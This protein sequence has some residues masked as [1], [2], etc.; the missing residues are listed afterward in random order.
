MVPRILVCVCVCNMSNMSIYI[1]SYGLTSTKNHVLTSIHKKVCISTSTQ[2]KVRWIHR[3]SLAAHICIHR[4]VI[5]TL[6]NTAKHTKPELPVYMS[7]WDTANLFEAPKR[8][9]SVKGNMPQKAKNNVIVL[10]TWQHLKCCVHLTTQ[11]YVV[12]CE[13][14]WAYVNGQRK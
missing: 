10:S 8:K 5:V 13:W 9:S 11:S 2:A 6:P 14:S 3:N 4:H 1:F 7:K 12:Q